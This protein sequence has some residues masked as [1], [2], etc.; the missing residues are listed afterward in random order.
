MGV[1]LRLRFV[2]G[3]GLGGVLQCLECC[4]GW[5]DATGPF[6]LGDVKWCLSVNV[7]AI[8]D[9]GSA[10]LRTNVSTSALATSFDTAFLSVPDCFLFPLLHKKRVVWTTTPYSHCIDS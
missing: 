8:P 7:I 5:F 1:L 6:A 2:I 9:S 4:G 10:P 3:R